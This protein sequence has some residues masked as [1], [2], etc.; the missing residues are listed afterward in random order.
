[1]HVDIIISNIVAYATVWY[2]KN[3]QLTKATFEWIEN[4]EIV[5]YIS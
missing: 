2:I 3:L 1:M 4:L 5:G